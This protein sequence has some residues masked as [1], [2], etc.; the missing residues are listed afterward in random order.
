MFIISVIGLLA[1]FGYFKAR[2]HQYQAAASVLLTLSPFEDTFTS[3]VNNQAIAETRAVAVLAAQELGPQQSAG[4]PAIVIHC[5]V[6][7]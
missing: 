3:G 7:H 6:R 5:R 1:G 2:P 4:Q